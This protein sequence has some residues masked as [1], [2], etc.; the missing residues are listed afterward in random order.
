M[1]ELLKEIEG[2]NKY[3]LS[4]PKKSLFMAMVINSL[5]ILR[6]VDYYLINLLEDKINSYKE[7]NNI[8]KD[9]IYTEIMNI[10]IDYIYDSNKDMNDGDIGRD[11]INNYFT[12]GYVFHSFNAGLYDE[13][14]RNGL[15]VKDRMIDT[16]L[17][18]EVAKI[19]KKRNAQVFGLYDT[20]RENSIFFAGTLHNI[21]QYGVGSP[22]F[23]RKFIFQSDKEDSYLKRDY[24]ECLKSVLMTIDKYNLDDNEKEI[25]LEFFNKYYE[26]FSLDKYY[27]AMYKIKRNINTSYTKDDIKR[28]FK[29]ELYHDYRVYE[30]ITPDDLI[31]INS[32]IF[33]KKI[34]RGR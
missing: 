29:E 11:I 20:K 26:I 31:L 4:E 12:N 32:D 25:V 23:F 15:L 1:E 17:F 3:N 27:I 8:N 34:K 5:I 30:D 13:I 24:N 18:R 14:N 19:F 2:V 7:I 21:Y 22:S 28:V 33:D 10:I 6:K 9:S 16:D